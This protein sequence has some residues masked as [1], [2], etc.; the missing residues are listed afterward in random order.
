A[1][2]IHIRHSREARL[3][4]GSDRHMVSPMTVD[5]KQYH[6]SCHGLMAHVGRRISRIR[7]RHFPYA[8][9]EA[10]GIGVAFAASIVCEYLGDD[11]TMVSGPSQERS[12]AQESGCS[13]S[14]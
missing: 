1:P 13:I 11:T 2:S 6:I 3:P 14:V 8:Q 5:R 12:Y 9:H 10:L 7:P 4:P